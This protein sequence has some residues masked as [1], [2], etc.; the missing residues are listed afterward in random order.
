MTQK[1]VLVWSEIPVT[2]LP[3][4]CAFYASVFGYK[5]EID[6]SGPNPMAVLNGEMDAPAGNL[7]PGNPAA[8]GS[9]PTLHLALAPGDTVEAA[10]ERVEAG[11]GSVPGPLVEMPFGRWSYATDPDGNSIGLFQAAG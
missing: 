8:A 6:E 9:G 1:P 10:C 4:S 2:D 5:M 3:R 7:Y 11:G